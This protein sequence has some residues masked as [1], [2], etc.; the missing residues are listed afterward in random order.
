M[1]NIKLMLV[2]L[3]L[4]TSVVMAQQPEVTTLMSKEL[5]DIPGKEVEMITVEYA[6]GGEDPIH[7]HNAHAFVYVLEGTIVMGLKGG[8]QVTLNPGDTFYEGP[9]DI[10]T[11]GRNAS[12]TKPAKF[13]VFFL[14]DKGAPILVPVTNQ[15]KTGK[16]D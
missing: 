13:L 15:S 8:K 10:H 5:K 16:G 14:K 2:S 7:R 6:P 11:V 4:M 1:T 9:D 3:F 12:S